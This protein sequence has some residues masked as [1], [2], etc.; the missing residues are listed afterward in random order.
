MW[1]PESFCAALVGMRLHKQP[2]LGCVLET[3]V[4]GSSRRGATLQAMGSREPLVTPTQA[5][6][7]WHQC[8][9]EWDSGP[10]HQGRSSRGGDVNTFC[11]QLS[12][13][14]MAKW[15]AGCKFSQEEPNNSGTAGNGTG[16]PC[17]IPGTGTDD[18]KLS[19]TGDLGHKQGWERPWWGWSVRPLGAFRALTK[20]TF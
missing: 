1:P 19:W 20:D 10:Q 16:Y 6:C 9:L 2:G 12:N 17:G 14:A 7:L 11:W 4:P 3:K 13:L 5:S 8:L 18:A 15:Q